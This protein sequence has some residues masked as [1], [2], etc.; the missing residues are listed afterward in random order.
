MLV[1]PH[2]LENMFH[3]C[4]IMKT[5]LTDRLERHKVVQAFW[6]W[7]VLTYFTRFKPK[8]VLLMLYTAGPVDGYLGWI[9]VKG[10]GTLAFVKPDGYYVYWW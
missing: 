3:D 8:R 7:L 4:C 5:E 2:A 10:F 9:E 1:L 6:R